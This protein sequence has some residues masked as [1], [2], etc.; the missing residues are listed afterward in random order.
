M[1]VCPVHVTHSLHELVAFPH[2]APPVPEDEP[3]G[4]PPKPPLD[5]ELLLLLASVDPVPPIPPPPAAGPFVV[6]N[7]RQEGSTIAAISKE[8][9]T[10]RERVTLDRFGTLLVLPH[11]FVGA[12]HLG[13]LCVKGRL[14]ANA[15]GRESAA[16]SSGQN[17]MRRRL[18]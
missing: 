13:R 1:G 16:N 9:R 5:V 2:E 7:S 6:S 17:T 15:H 4:T 10:A 12:N 14:R 3:A 11:F 18:D 8:L